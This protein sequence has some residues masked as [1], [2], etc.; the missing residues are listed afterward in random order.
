MQFIA[1]VSKISNSVLSFFKL[2]CTFKDNLHE[3]FCSQYLSPD[4]HT[5]GCSA[6]CSLTESLSLAFFFILFLSLPP[7]LLLSSCL[8][9]SSSLLFPPSSLP[10]FLPPSFLPPGSL[11]PSLPPSLFPPSFLAC[12]LLSFLFKTDLLN[13]TERAL[14]TSEKINAKY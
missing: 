13:A 4:L 9:V 6:S 5:R 11:P 2:M 10:L 8:P 12:F 7:S 1:I 14:L 3:L